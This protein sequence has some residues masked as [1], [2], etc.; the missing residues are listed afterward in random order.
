MARAPKL[1]ASAICLTVPLVCQHAFGDNSAPPMERSLPEPGCC[2]V[3]PADHP[4]ITAFGANLYRSDDARSA[5]QPYR[6]PV[7]DA[8]G[9]TAEL[10]LTI[11]RQQARLGPYAPELLPPLQGLGAGYFNAGDWH[12]AD[13]AWTR[14]LHLLRVNE[15]LETPA[16]LPLLEQ[17]IELSLAAGRISLA[18]RQHRQLFALQRLH[19]RPE[20]QELQAATARYADWLRGAYLAGI[21][22]ERYR[23]LVALVNLYDDLIAEATA[24]TGPGGRA[25]LPYLQGRLQVAYLL[26]AYPGERGNTMSAGEGVESGNGKLDLIHFLEFKRDIF[27]EGERTAGQIRAILAGDSGSSA[28]ERAGALITQA[29]W[30]H[31]HRRYAQSLPLYEEAWVSVDDTAWRTERFA[32]PL[33]LPAGIVFQPGRLAPATRADTE[34][35]LRFSVNRHG[36]TSA[37]EVLSPRGQQ[38]SAMLVRLRDMI[39]ELRFRPRLEAGRAVDT[40]G[41]ERSY[42]VRY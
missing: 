7:P 41:L 30:Y 22:R 12:A 4:H 15:G 28:Q 38:D 26:S 36:K 3:T 40:P 24:A 42:R 31:W 10:E 8:S 37:L 33:E 20:Q 29:D 11:E 6:A 9:R 5:Y 34:L 16:Q 21:D 17:M 32:S 2:T 1:R 19:F 27:R 23:R 13:T 35:R 39:G 25:V 18:D 14:A